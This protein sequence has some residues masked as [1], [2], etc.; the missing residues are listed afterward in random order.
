MPCR[1]KPTQE[2]EIRASASI[3]IALYPK[4]GE[5]P[6]TL[7]KNADTAMYHAKSE[8]RGKFQ[9]YAQELNEQLTELMRLSTDLRTAL[10]RDQFE[11]HYQPKVDA[12]AGEVW[13]P[14]R[15][16]AGCTRSGA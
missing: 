9:F 16:C 2:H 8:G 13:G 3:G 10:E 5:D 1:L 15:W 12:Q 14:R 7:V 4:D 6:D 11:L